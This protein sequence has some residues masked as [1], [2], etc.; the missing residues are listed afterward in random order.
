MRVPGSIAATGD[1]AHRVARHARLAAGAQEPVK[2]LTQPGNRKDHD[3]DEEHEHRRKEQCDDL[4][5]LQ[6]GGG[7]R[8]LARAGA[9]EVRGIL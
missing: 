5:R 3:D 7:S 1:L 9:R 8:G 6:L 4:L 2:L